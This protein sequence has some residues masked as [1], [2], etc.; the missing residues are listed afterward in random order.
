MSIAER[1]QAVGMIQTG[2]SSR[3][4]HTMNVCSSVGQCLNNLINE[5]KR[6]RN[7]VREKDFFYS[8]Y[9]RFISDSTFTN[10]SKRLTAFGSVCCDSVYRRCIYFLLAQANYANADVAYVQRSPT[11]SNLDERIL[12]VGKL[13]VRVRQRL[14][15]AEHLTLPGSLVLIEEVATSIH[16]PSLYL[17]TVKLSCRHARERQKAKECVDKEANQERRRHRIIRASCCCSYA[18]PLRYHRVHCVG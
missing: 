13:E 11:Q 14:Y 16:L 1:G 15:I 10:V 12:S 9:E 17:V 2:T 7:Y 3:W 8:H 18:S 5:P 6:R 4:V